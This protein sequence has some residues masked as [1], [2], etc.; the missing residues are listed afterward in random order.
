MPYNP[1][2]TEETAREIVLCR[3]DEVDSPNGARPL[4]VFADA[5]FACGLTPKVLS[6][7]TLSNLLC[8][9]MYPGLTD[10]DGKAFSWDKVPRCSRGRRVAVGRAKGNRLH[11]LELR[12][13]Q[14]CLAV[15]RIAREVGVE[16]DH[17]KL[18]GR[19]EDDSL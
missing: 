10:R 12:V 7:A 16:I 6:K 9:R 8:G 13:H 15:S 11:R 19:D 17:D 1:V 3:L 5:M 14:M 18:L 2:L 4:N